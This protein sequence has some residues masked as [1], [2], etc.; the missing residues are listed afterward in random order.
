[1][2]TTMHKGTVH[3]K[4]DTL[5]VILDF[6]DTIGTEKALDIATGTGFTAFALAPKVDSVVATDLT[7]EM[8]L[9]ASELAQEANS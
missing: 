3:A 8:V 5:D 1:M 4:G 2:L 9:K 7:P 6:A